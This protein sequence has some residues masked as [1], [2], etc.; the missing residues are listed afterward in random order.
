MNKIHT[1]LSPVRS[2]GSAPVDSLLRDL[3]TEAAELPSDVLERLAS[4]RHRAVAASPHHRRSTETTLHRLRDARPLSPSP[5][6]GTAQTGHWLRHG[7]QTFWH[8]R[9]MAA[10]MASCCVAA[11]AAVLVVTLAPMQDELRPENSAMTGPTSVLASRDM[12]ADTATPT[13]EAASFETPPVAT[14]PDFTSA[15]NLDLLGSVDFLLW[16]DAQQG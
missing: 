8:S 2:R 6:T 12:A 13:I 15:E 11:L 3:N 16:L 10:S 1:S 9:P 5:L 14:V 7:L 4:A